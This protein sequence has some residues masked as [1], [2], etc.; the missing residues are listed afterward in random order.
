MGT[1]GGENTHNFRKDMMSERLLLPPIQIK[2]ISR[3]KVG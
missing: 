3:G 1:G 2:L